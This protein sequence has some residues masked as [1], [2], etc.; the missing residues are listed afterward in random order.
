MVW[1]LGV[2]V[3]GQMQRGPEGKAMRSYGLSDTI[4]PALEPSS[5]P[6]LWEKIL[7]NREGILLFHLCC[8]IRVVVF[9][10]WCNEQRHRIMRRVRDFN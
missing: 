1:G 10:S 7:Q 3:I 5:D 4:Q 2:G 6:P 8:T 9:M